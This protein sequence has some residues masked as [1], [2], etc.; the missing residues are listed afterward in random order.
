[1]TSPQ[2]SPQAFPAPLDT[3][4]PVHLPRTTHALNHAP[5]VSDDPHA[6][7]RAALLGDLRDRVTLT[8]AQADWI[9]R[10][11]NLEFTRPFPRQDAFNWA[12]RFMEYARIYVPAREEDTE[13]PGPALGAPD[14]QHLGDDLW[15]LRNMLNRARDFLRRVDDDARDRAYFADMLELQGE[16]NTH[17]WGYSRIGDTPGQTTPNPWEEC[18]HAQQAAYDARHA[19]VLETLWAHLAAC[20]PTLDAEQHATLRR[21]CEHEKRDVETFVLTYHAV[22]AQLA[23][24][25][26]A[27]WA[28]LSATLRRPS[29]WQIPWP[30]SG[31]APF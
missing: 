17:P 19:A 6:D 22:A 9:T 25:D 18:L 20:F 28:R 7:I 15:S 13:R 10:L 29:D 23:P 3:L 16:R 31:E 11:M 2:P 14:V 30:A 8:D 26:E 4:Y 5:R 21:A 27:N 1:M 12:D 24:V